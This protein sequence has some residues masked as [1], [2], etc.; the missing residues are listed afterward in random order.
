MFPGASQIAKRVLRY[1]ALERVFHDPGGHV[2]L[3]GRS[4]EDMADHPGWT[5]TDAG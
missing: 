4:S 1:D 3:E 5:G 2:T